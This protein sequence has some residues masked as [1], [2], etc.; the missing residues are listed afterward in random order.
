MRIAC[1]VITVINSNCSP[2]RVTRVAAMAS[3]GGNVDL[4]TISTVVAGVLTSLQSTSQANAQ[5]SPSTG[6]RAASSAQTG[7][8]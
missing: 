5:A 2:A 3:S 4:N 1:A 8:R 7:S 6:S